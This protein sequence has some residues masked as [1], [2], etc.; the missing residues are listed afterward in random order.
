MPLLVTSN[1]L[2]HWTWIIN[3]KTKSLI[4]SDAAKKYCSVM[5]I[6]NKPIGNTHQKADL[7]GSVIDFSVMG[8]KI[9]IYLALWGR[10]KMENR[11]LNQRW[12]SILGENISIKSLGWEKSQ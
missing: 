4:A 11:D 6:E 12:H 5:D 1:T 10:K 2:Q 3:Q 9:Y 8:K 7:L